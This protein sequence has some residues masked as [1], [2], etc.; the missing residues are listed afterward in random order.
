MLSTPTTVLVRLQGEV[1]NPAA[2]SVPQRILVLRIHPQVFLDP[3]RLPAP[4][5][6]SNHPR[7]AGMLTNVNIPTLL[8]SPSPPA[9]P[10]PKGKRAMD[11]FLEEIKRSD[12]TA[13]R[14]L[15]SY[16]L[17]MLQQG[18]RQTGRLGLRGIVSS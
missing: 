4:C 9:V 10:R 16:S 3:M 17:L 7:C 5:A 8:Q 11:A 1:R 14:S 2:S 13:Q 18:T 12:R 6:H 15:L